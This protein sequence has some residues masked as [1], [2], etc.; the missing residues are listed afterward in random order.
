MMGTSYELE[1]AVGAMADA[2]EEFPDPEERRVIRG[3]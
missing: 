1:Q 2:R 3:L